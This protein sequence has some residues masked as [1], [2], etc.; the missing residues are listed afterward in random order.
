MMNEP[1]LSMRQAIE[2]AMQIQNQN[3]Q[4]WIVEGAKGHPHF[5]PLETKNYSFADATH[6]I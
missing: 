5:W 4:S 3:K 1:N 6:N 2:M